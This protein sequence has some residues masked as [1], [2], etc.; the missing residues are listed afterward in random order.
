MSESRP[1]RTPAG[2]INVEPVNAG[3]SAPKKAAAAPAR[4]AG[5]G[6]LVRVKSV[7]TW[8]VMRAGFVLSL[9]IAIVILVAVMTLWALFAASGVFDSLSRI[10]DDVVG[11][12]AN[13]EVWFSFSRVVLITAVIAS[14]EVVLTTAALTLVAALYNLAAGWVGGIEITLVDD[15]AP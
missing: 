1:V 9:A 6:A 13:A 7:D 14:I 8:S 15:R 11:A 10:I 5:R 2:V 4:P 3:P 12:S